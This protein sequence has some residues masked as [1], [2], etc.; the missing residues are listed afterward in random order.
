MQAPELLSHDHAFV[1]AAFTILCVCLLSLGG[2]VRVLV[3]PPHLISILLLR[4]NKPPSGDPSEGIVTVDFVSDNGPVVQN[5][6]NAVIRLRVPRDGNARCGITQ[7][8]TS[9]AGYLPIASGRP[10]QQMHLLGRPVRRV[11]VRSV[12]SGSIE[13]PS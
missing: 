1:G 13:S 8:T 6:K 2:H 10:Y 4:D 5:T 7:G 3:M 9:A 11:G 12:R